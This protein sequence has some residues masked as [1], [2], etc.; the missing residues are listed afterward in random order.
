MLFAGVQYIYII[1]SAVLRPVG[2]D[3]HGLL[4]GLSYPAFEL[5][6]HLMMPNANEHQH[7]NILLKGLVLASVQ[8]QSS[9]SFVQGPAAEALAGLPL[10]I[11][12]LARRS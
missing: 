2:R 1:R 6:R 7:S 5:A 9:T 8:Q 4:G 10:G 11:R 12:E 3:T